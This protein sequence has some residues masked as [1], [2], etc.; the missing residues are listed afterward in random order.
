[1]MLPSFVW[2][3]GT[4]GEGRRAL[5]LLIGSLSRLNQ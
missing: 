3:G 1:M 5:S 4:D 2:G